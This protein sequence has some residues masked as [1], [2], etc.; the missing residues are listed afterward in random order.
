MFSCSSAARV[1]VGAF[2]LSRPVC[3]FARTLTLADVFM[4]SRDLGSIMLGE[5]SA[6]SMQSLRTFGAL[7]HQDTDI[8]LSGIVIF[9]ST[10]YAV[11]GLVWVSY[12]G[13]LAKK[14]HFRAPRVVLLCFSWACMS[15]SLHVLN[16]TLVAVLRSPALISMVQ[17]G[18]CSIIMASTS[19]S[20][21]L[22]VGRE[23]L[24]SWMVVPFLFSG[25]LCTS[26][27]TFEYI[28]LSVLTIV[29]NLSPLVGLAIEMSIM[30]VSKR[31]LVTVWTVASILIMILGAWVYGHG[32]NNVSV[33][34]ILFAVLNMMLA[35]T[36]RVL[37]RWLLTGPCTEMT[38]GVCTFVSNFVGM[39]PTFCIA[40]ATKEANRLY[41]DGEWEVWAR[42]QVLILLVLS[43]IVGMSINYL[44]FECQREIS[45]TSFFVMQNVSKIFVVICGVVVFADPFTATTV[46]GVLLSVSG[47]FLY[48]RTQTVM[49]HAGEK[50]DFVKLPK[51]KGICETTPLLK[52]KESLKDVVKDVKEVKECGV[53]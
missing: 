30:P 3:A 28:S 33:V 1:A 37:Q 44:G 45:A 18:I 2:A 40:L 27:Y 12:A 26:F 21:L 25:M 6:D 10:L 31:P 35:V 17:M 47:S 42:P 38:S 22:D 20:K 7:D 24:L 43:G 34:G 29:R 15:V 23:Q 46:S 13:A 8:Q 9:T 14:P 11:C 32:V 52:L 53:A 50:G 19:F 16:M 41:D 49:T 36:D 48:S 39:L 4:P 51:G 5:S